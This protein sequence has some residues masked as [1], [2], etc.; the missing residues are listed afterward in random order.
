MGQIKRLKLGPGRGGSL[1][2]RAFAGSGNSVIPME[3]SPFILLSLGFDWL[4]K[5]KRT[6][7]LR[8]KKKKENLTGLKVRNILIC[9]FYY[10]VNYIPLDNTANQPEAQNKYL[11][12][13]PPFGLFK[14]KAFFRTQKHR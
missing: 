12:T 4:T 5:R 7:F 10:S 9:P 8:I 2:L 14:I 11:T 1:N 6:P 13:K 3:E